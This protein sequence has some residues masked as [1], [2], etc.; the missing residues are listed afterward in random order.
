MPQQAFV[1]EVAKT[2]GR[3]CHRWPFG[4]N[5]CQ[6]GCAR[7]C[8]SDFDGVNDDVNDGVLG[9]DLLGHPPMKQRPFRRQQ[10]HGESNEHARH[11][12]PTGVHFA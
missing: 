4:P 6:F 7:P 2:S 8:D 1:A 10:R 9:G 3:A 12:A 5:C 11:G